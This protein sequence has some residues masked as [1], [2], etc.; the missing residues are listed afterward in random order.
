MTT[1]LQVGSQTIQA[2]EMLSL[3]QRYQMLPQVLRGLVIDQAIAPFTCT[4][5][6][7]QQAISLFDQHQQLES[8][9]A[10]EVW[11]S[12]HDM[13]LAQYEELAVRPLLIEKFKRSQ[14]SHLVEPRFLQRKRDLDQGIYS[15]IRT[16]DMGLASEL[17]FRILEGE[18]SFSEL[19]EQYSAGAEAQMGGMIGP[20]PLSQAHPA[21]AQ[22]LI[23]SQ[24]GKLWSPRMIGE[25]AVI[26]RLERLIP[27]QL[28][29]AMQQR[30]IS[31]LFELWVQ[32]Q[33]QERLG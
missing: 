4:E 7:R 12:R 23:A 13:T 28:D 33:V 8:E 16:K 18:Q 1:A 19:A 11:L 30:M 27:A 22:L 20:V 31:E 9:A 15:L 17:Y 29:E 2:E 25:W 32:E 10:R 14:W 24:P 6:E 21:L 26:V 5:E 3:L